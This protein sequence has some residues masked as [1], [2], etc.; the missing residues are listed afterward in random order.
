MPLADAVMVTLPLAMPA[1]CPGF[2]VP[3]L[4]TV[5]FVVSDEDHSAELVR[6]WVLPS[7]KFPVAENWTV[8]A[9]STLAV[10]GATV[11]E[12]I[13]GA[14]TVMLAEPFTVPEAAVIVAVP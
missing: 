10:A 7:L 5:A 9:T 11:S 8:A 6:F 13:T 3:E 12:V 2:E 1:A 4:S 14:E